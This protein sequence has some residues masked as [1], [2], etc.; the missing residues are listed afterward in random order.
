MSME[1]L[2]CELELISQFEKYRFFSRL[3]RIFVVDG[4]RFFHQ[5][6][7]FFSSLD[8]CFKRNTVYMASENSVAKICLPRLKLVS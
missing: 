7:N 5:L 6:T 8:T 2:P 1:L 3:G 4:K